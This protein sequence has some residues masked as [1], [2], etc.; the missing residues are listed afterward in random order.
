M[1]AVAMLSAIV[2]S[3]GVM[4]HVST[5]PKSMS[6]QQV[7]ITAASIASTSEGAKAGAFGVVSAGAAIGAS[8]FYTGAIV[9]GATGVGA[10]VAI[11]QGLLGAICTL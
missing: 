6:V 7:S 8:N 2:M 11:A 4:G 9:S 3:M 5:C 10:P 1:P